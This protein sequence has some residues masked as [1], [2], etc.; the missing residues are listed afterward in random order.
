MSIDNIAIVLL[1]SNKDNVFFVYVCTGICVYK[2][3]LY[4]FTLQQLHPSN[5][6]IDL[7]ILFSC[8]IDLIFLLVNKK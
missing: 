1:Q 5:P 4:R 2:H 3:Y 8:P 6:K 7:F